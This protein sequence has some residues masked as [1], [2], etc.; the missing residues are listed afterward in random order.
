MAQAALLKLAFV[1]NWAE[2][3]VAPGIH[4]AA[5]DMVVAPAGWSAAKLR[6]TTLFADC[7][8]Q[9]R[10]SC[11]SLMRQTRWSSDSLPAA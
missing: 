5:S 8:E 11:Q 10:A 4:P 1:G 6:F 2:L 3:T 7:K 9:A